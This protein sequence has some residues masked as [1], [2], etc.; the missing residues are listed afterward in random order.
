[1]SSIQFHKLS[2]CDVRQQTERGVS[3]VFTVP[4]SLLEHYRFIAGQ[5]LTLRADIDG[6]DVRRSYSICSSVADVK[7]LEVGVKQV[8]GGLFSNY[9]KT[10]KVG[11][12]VDVMPPQ[13]RFT[14]PIGNRQD[15]HDYL[16]IAA[17]S[18]ITP[19]LSIIRSV[20]AEEPESTLSLVYG[21]RSSNTIMFRDEIGALKD[22]YLNR[23]VVNHVMSRE[24][25]DVAFLNGRIDAEKIETM[26]EA[27]VVHTSNCDGIYICGPSD[28]TE[29]V[30]AALKKSGV[31]SEIIHTELFFV[32]GAPRRKPSS[33]AIELPQV[34]CQ[35]TII[36][37]GV[38]NKIQ[39]DGNKDTVLQ[40]AIAAGLDMPFSC[41]G[42][43]CCTCRCKIADGQ[44]Q[45]D[46]NYSL[47]DWEIEAGFTLAC[48]SRP[49][50]DTL[51]LDFDAT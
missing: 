47:A 3:L 40:A 43:M 30:A 46:V 12:S 20:L 29:S 15:R 34:G 38:E 10:L 19:C 51:V 9:A 27:G 5:Y 44:A 31:A 16:L 17:G 49:L 36:M 4:E 18:G 45:M 1:M 7:Q 33:E 22:R 37:D 41:A 26:V 48:Q 13:G 8:D 42:G 50:T 35:V 11:D 28:M 14:A 6:Q 2:I 39:V 32:D 21:N 25:Q 23:F 24:R